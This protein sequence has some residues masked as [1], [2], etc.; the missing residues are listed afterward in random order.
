MA[1]QK[2]DEPAASALQGVN[3][4]QDQPQR[5]EAELMRREDDIRSHANA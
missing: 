5:A 3:Q 2:Q 1:I 4:N